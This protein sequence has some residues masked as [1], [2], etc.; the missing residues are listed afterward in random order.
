MVNEPD[1]RIYDVRTADVRVPFTYYVI[2]GD[3]PS[4]R[5][6]AQKA[7]TRSLNLVGLVF[8]TPSIEAEG[9][10]L[11]FTEASFSRNSMEIHL[12]LGKKYARTELLAQVEWYERRSPDA[13]IVGV[14][15]IDIPAD[16]LDT[17]RNFIKHAR[18][19]G[20]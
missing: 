5:T 18:L 13:F 9:F 1:D 14:N 20:R 3:D 10:H 2:H 4:R 6:S 11:S 7:V 17:L 16:A 8:E 15:F 12:D 19:A